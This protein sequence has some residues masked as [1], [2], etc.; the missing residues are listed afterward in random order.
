MG[1]FLHKLRRG[2]TCGP[3]GGRVMVWLLEVS[4]T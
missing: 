4:L 1:R 2:V 3:E